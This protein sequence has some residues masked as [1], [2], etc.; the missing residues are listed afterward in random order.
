MA[1]LDLP[2]ELRA[3]LAAGRKLE[4]DASKCEAGR[5]ELRSLKSLRLKEYTL[6]PEESQLGRQDPHAGEDGYYLVPGI[7]LV[8]RCKSYDPDGI[9]L[10]LPREER[11]GTWD[12][13]HHVIQVFPWATWADIVADPVR[14]LNA[15]WAYPDAATTER[16]I[17]WRKYPF[18]ANEEGE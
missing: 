4:Y 2:D 18:R 3:F 6:R 8:G 12:C 10:W 9:L 11:F 5:I 14:H 1:D 16:L 13:D 17:P 7:S 15:Q